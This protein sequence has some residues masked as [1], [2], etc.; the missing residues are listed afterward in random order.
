MSTRHI[1][2]KRWLLGGQV[3][4]VGF[5]PFVYRLAR[6]LGL[7]GWVLNR[8]GRVEIHTEGEPAAQEAFGR[9]LLEHAP[10]LA[11]P[12]LLRVETCAPSYVEGFTI[13]RSEQ[14]GDTDIH[15]PPDRFTCDDCLRELHDPADRRYYYPFVNCTQCGPRYT[16]ITALPYDRA[17]TSMAG[18]PLCPACRREYE[19]PANRRFHAEPIACPVCGP[20]L[21]F[22]HENARE[23]DTNAALQAC[24]AALRA[25]RIVAVKGIGGYHLMC[26]A[27][28][29]E[30]I[31]RLRRRKPRPDK[32][33][34]VMFP[35]PLTDPLQPVLREVTLNAEEEKAL[36]SPV[37]PILLARRRADGTLAGEIAPGL[38]EIGVMLPYSPL[39]HLLLDAFGGPLVATSGNISGEPVLTDSG[40]AEQRLGHITGTFLHHDR[41]IVRPADD[42]VYR[43]MGERLRPLRLGRGC[44]PA[45]FALPFTLK[46]PCIAV[47]GQMKNS[48]ALA[49]EDRVVLSPHI[50]DMGTTRS[51]AV[52]EQLVEDLQRLY[53]VRARK[54]ICDAHPDYATTRW[55][56]R[57]GLSVV[58]V[59]HHAAHASALAGEQNIHRHWLIFTWDGVGFGADGTLWGGEALTGRPGA[60]ERVASFRPFHLPG[61]DKAAREPWRSAVAICWEMGR[62]WHPPH[63]TDTA[64]TLL[65]R[66]WERR[67]NSPQ[68]S[69]AGRLFDAAAALAG[70]CFDASFEGQGPMALEALATASAEPLTLPMGQ[71]EDGL[72]ITDWQPL[73]EALLDRGWDPEEQAARFHATLA[74]ALTRQALRIRSQRPVEAV[75]L[76]GG[77]FQ[78]R[79]LCELATS[80]LEAAGFRV[81]LN[82][83][84][85]TNDGG[86]CFGQIIEHGARKE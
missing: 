54:V 17:N 5:R 43:F 47:G 44:A 63:Q 58:P 11:S 52:F 81:F 42:P 85:P 8:M 68:T 76:A 69:A 40:Q 74:D 21:Y 23:N 3:Q 7:K 38:K 18:F 30:A 19:D 35:A 59:F 51:I 55:A 71:R 46:Q 62:K 56:R 86:L 66:A 20:R 26:D 37:R 2:A 1:E 73:F 65:R 4:G 82:E 31:R 36:L 72:W 10:P 6:E 49:W 13:R 77:V 78:N 34:A 15:L 45:E 83:R 57:S 50:G 80:R 22:H 16:L 41:P 28:N 61:G 39:H 9:A 75:G 48:V 67:F 27:R 33:L 12:R 70:I 79:T 14:A 24:V 32:P 84:V 60:W 53:G 25:G 64:L 29:S